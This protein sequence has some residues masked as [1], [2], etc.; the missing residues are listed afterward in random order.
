MDSP[1]FEE[2]STH[3]NTYMYIMRIRIV[4]DSWRERERGIG[5]GAVEV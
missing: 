3:A 1:E 4:Y 2:K 5:V